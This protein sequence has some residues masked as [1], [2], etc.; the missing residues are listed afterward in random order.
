MQ[1]TQRWMLKLQD[2]LFFLAVGLPLLLSTDAP[3]ANSGESANGFSIPFGKEWFESPFD[4]SISSM[5]PLKIIHGLGDARIIMESLFDVITWFFVC[6]GEMSYLQ[7][8][9]PNPRCSLSPQAQR[10]A[11]RLLQEQWTLQQLDFCLCFGSC[12]SSFYGRSQSW[13]ASYYYLSAYCSCY[14]C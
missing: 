8:A 4:S 7:M 6:R 11:R 14:G 12:C 9:T 3:F 13:S 1:S 5:S 10:R 2:L